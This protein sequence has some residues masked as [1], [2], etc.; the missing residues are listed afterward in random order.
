MNDSVVP[1]REV[2]AGFTRS[3]VDINAAKDLSSDRKAAS[4][5][6]VKAMYEQVAKGV[7]EGVPWNWGY[8]S[9]EN[10]ALIG[11]R[12]SVYRPLCTD[13]FSEQ[14]Y[15]FA[16]ARTGIEESSDRR[17]LDVGC[18]VGQGL[19]FLSRVI[20]AREL[21]GL[22]ISQS[23]VDL[24]NSRL[25]RRSLHFVAGDAENLPFED[26]TVDVVLNIES[27]HTYPDL[28]RFFQEVA[29][30]LSPG[31]VFS[32][33]DVFTE[34]RYAQLRA[35][36]RDVGLEWVEETDISE[37]VRR[38]VRQRMQPGSVTRR[39]LRSVSTWPIPRALSEPLALTTLGAPF[40]AHRFGPTERFWTSLYSSM[41]GKEGSRLVFTRYLHCL[42][43]KL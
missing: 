7:Q 42:A 21:I 40:V 28:R 30:V 13:G 41:V 17:V 19:N 1:S 16:L 3:I 38:A 15:F 9:E 18:G 23:A 35:C 6:S 5:A 4:K 27:S 43:R 11:E 12:L 36:Q 32:Y 2:L 22:D 37:P 39:Q 25:A 26:G 34:E 14:L 10:R 33:A 8:D 20:E 29:R 24:A 31:G